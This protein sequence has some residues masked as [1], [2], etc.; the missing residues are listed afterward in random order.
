MSQTK[1]LSLLNACGGCAPERFQAE[2]DKVLENIIDPNTDAK[3]VREV[4]LRLRIKPDE[5]RDQLA[6]EM[7]VAS[8]L[9]GLASVRALGIIGRSI[10]GKPEA[11]E[12][13]RP[14][15]QK[16]FPEEGGKVTPMTKTI[17]KG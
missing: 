11:H 17:V 16:L 3:A 13:S 10:E 14:Q 15:Q 8:K 12:Y 5:N 2:L 1:E 4:V 9:A 6:I 7:T